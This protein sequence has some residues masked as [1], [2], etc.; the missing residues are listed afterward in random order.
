MKN[1]VYIKDLREN[2]GKEVTI[3]GWVN[4]RRDQGKMVFFDMRD[5]TGLVQCVALPAHADVIG[6]CKEIRLEWVL[7]ITGIVNKRPEKNV[8]QGVLNG[9]IELEITNIEVLS[10]AMPLPFDMSLDGYN[11]DLTTELNNRS[12]F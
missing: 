9:D 7:K 4:I 6:Q 8:K 5:M 3:A 2:I 11:L 1:R 12:W 10:E